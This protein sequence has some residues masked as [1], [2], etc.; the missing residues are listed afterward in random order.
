MA[1]ARPGRG[2]QHRRRHGRGEHHYYDVALL[3]V[4][5]G[6]LDRGPGLLTADELRHGSFG[7]AED[8]FFGVEVGQGAVPFLVR[9]PVDAAAIGGAHAQGWS[10]R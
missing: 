4:Q 7:G 2:D 10:R 5:L 9:R 6:A 3:G 1:L 8:L